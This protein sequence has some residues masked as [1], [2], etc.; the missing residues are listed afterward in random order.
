MSECFSLASSVHGYSNRFWDNGSYIIPMAK[1]FGKKS[2]ANKGCMLWNDLPL[3]LR[4]IN[5]LREFKDAVKKLF[6]ASMNCKCD[7]LVVRY[8]F[9]IFCVDFSNTRSHLY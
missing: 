3:Y 7:I 8:W 2:F 4:K 6:I 9:Y 1:G 5:G